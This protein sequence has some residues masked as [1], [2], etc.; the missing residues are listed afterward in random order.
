MACGTPVIVSD[1][2]VLREVGGSAAYYC[3]VGDIDAWV[4]T[5]VR[6]A[7]QCAEHGQL[8]SD[9]CK[10]LVE[11]ASKFSWTENAARTADI[12]REMLSAS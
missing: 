7:G 2:P 3:E 10:R 11:Q 6:V 9:Q 4:N 1:L 5:I 8:A 12:Y